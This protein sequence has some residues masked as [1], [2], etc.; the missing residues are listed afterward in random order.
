MR[1]QTITPF[2]TQPSSRFPTDISSSSTKTNLA[3]AGD[4]TRLISDPFHINDGVRFYWNVC[5][6]FSKNFPGGSVCLSLGV[7]GKQ[8]GN[9]YIRSGGKH[10]Q[11]HFIPAAVAVTPDPSTQTKHRMMY[12]AVVMCAVVLVASAHGPPPHSRP[13]ATCRYWCKTPEG[14]A[15]CCEGSNRPT[16]PLTVKP[17]FCPP[18]R[19]VCPPVRSFPG[20]PV[21]CS[22]DGSC[23]GADKCCFDRCLGEHVCKAPEHRTPHPPHP[24]PYQ[25]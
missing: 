9:R 19:P 6:T 24:V 12:S 7:V 1:S 20:P 10:D 2:Y 3:K 25:H 5:T 13:G 15:Y 18:V 11:R 8:P 16:G 21:T 4:V 14:A 22:N 17:G 23:G